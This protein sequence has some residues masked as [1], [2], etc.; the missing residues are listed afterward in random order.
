MTLGATFVARSFSGDKEQL[1]PLI[2]AGLRHRG[3]AL[4]DVLSPCVTFNDHEGSTKSYAYTREHYEPAMHADFVPLEREIT[5]DYPEGETLPLVMHDGS[6]IVL[7]KLDAAYDPTNRTTAAAHI[8]ERMKAGEYLTGLL[9]VEPSQNE[10]HAV[11][12]TPEQALNS[13][14]YAVL[15]PGSQGLQKILAATAERRAR[16]RATRYPWPRGAVSGEVTRARWHAHGRSVFAGAAAR[17][18]PCS[19]ADYVGRDDPC[20]RVPPTCCLHLNATWA[21]L[22]A[23]GPLRYRPPPDRDLSLSCRLPPALIASWL[24]SLKSRI[25]LDQVAECAR[26]IFRRHA[27]LLVQNA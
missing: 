20:S 17:R 24:P 10:F 12:A 13:V 18:L 26:P 16:A 19:R 15:S 9:Y 3:F 14:P 22:C 21:D 23:A 1:V 4:I 8:Q 7:R 27:L 6:R 2:Q 25:V 5:A 11:N